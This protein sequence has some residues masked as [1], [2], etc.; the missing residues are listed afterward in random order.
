VKAEELLSKF[1]RKELLEDPRPP[2]MRNIAGYNDHVRSTVVNYCAMTGQDIVM[3]YLYSKADLGAAVHDHC[4][5][6]RPFTECWVDSALQ[7]MT[8]G[9]L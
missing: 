9:L 2:S 3:R 1:R 8:V 5:L 4:Y 6:S 7:V